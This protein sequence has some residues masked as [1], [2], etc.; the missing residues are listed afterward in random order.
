MPMPMPMP[1]SPGS[2]GSRPQ[3]PKSLEPQGQHPQGQ[4][5][6]QQQ[7][8]QA[9][10]AGWWRGTAEEFMAMAMSSAPPPQQQ[11][12]AQPAQPSHGEVESFWGPRDLAKPESQAPPSPRGWPSAPTPQPAPTEAI[13]Q[14]PQPSPQPEPEPAIEPAKQQ[15]LPSQKQA[16][17]KQQAP[18]KA[19]AQPKQ[20]KKVAPQQQAAPTSQFRKTQP[21][22]RRHAEPGVEFE[23]EAPLSHHEKQSQREPWAN[24]PQQ[25]QQQAKSLREI[26]EEER[27]EKERRAKDAEASGGVPQQGLLGHAPGI[28]AAS[29]W[30]SQ[31]Q[32]KAQPPAISLRQIQEEEL[33]RKKDEPSEPSASPPTS[34]PSTPSSWPAATSPGL[35]TNMVPVAALAGVMSAKGSEPGAWGGWSGSGA[36][37]QAPSLREIQSLQEKEGER[38]A[39]A[40]APPPP[41]ASAWASVASSG[42]PAAHQQL[43]PMTGPSPTSTQLEPK[44]AWAAPAKSHAVTE[45]PA[46]PAPTAAVEK[47]KRAT[48]AAKNVEDELF[49]GEEAP[50]PKRQENFPSLSGAKQ[51]P[52][53]QPKTAKQP[54]GQQKEPKPATASTKNAFGGPE[55]SKEFR[56]WCRQQLSNIVGEREPDL[57]LVEFLF[58]LKSKLEVEEYAHQYLGVS[59]KVSEFV[60]GFYER[61]SFEAEGAAAAGAGKTKKRQK[62]GAK[63]SAELLGFTVQSTERINVG[64]VA[65]VED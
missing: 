13:P 14:K 21:D 40:G 30:G 65:K 61:R 64:E 43:P 45:P 26:Q 42:T 11:Q 17:Q 16:K 33:R 59:S 8:G 7:T 28:P 32:A 9:P 24:A 41:K 54:A 50:Q 55:M 56:L 36:T 63:V 37:S 19:S 20:T 10:F 44:G 60:D 5:Q 47:K 1:P 25:Q 34:L 48:K 52:P 46:P 57:T 6:S 27:R 4:G 58:S 15:A 31:E 49:W 51:Q 12:P 29:A 22:G 53:A 38:K 23:I 39:D 18:A 2:Q 62:K 3:Q 35:K